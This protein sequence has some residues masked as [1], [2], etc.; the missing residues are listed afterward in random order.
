MS[1]KLTKDFYRQI[2]DIKEVKYHNLSTFSYVHGGIDFRD[3]RVRLTRGLTLD[4]N[5]NVILVGYSKFFCNNQLDNRDIEEDFKEQYAV[6][7][8]KEIYHCREKLDGSMI[9]LG[10]YQNELI[11]ST[12]SSVD[13]EYTREILPKFKSLSFV[14][15]LKQYLL[16]RNSCFIFEY[17]SPLNRVVVEYDKT[18]FVLLDE[19]SKDT[20]KRINI[21]NDFNFTRPHEYYLSKEEINNMV[22]NSQNFE[23][24]VIENNYNNYIKVKSNWW[25]DN[26]NITTD[27]FFSNKLT[28]NIIKAIIQNIDNLDELYS[29][30]NSNAYWKDKNYVGIIED[31]YNQLVLE[32]DKML[33]KYHTP[34]EISLNV[35]DGFIKALAITKLMNRDTERLFIKAITDRLENK[36]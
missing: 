29:Y 7:Q 1:M 20:F 35:K 4:E 5:N 23:G 33:E 14:N 11:C 28:K 19:I 15:E 27:I 17:I 31:E 36:S 9:I 26:K 34:K 8:D 24:Y 18:D 6:L 10:V 2:K 32:I 25:Y 16:D 12:T 21:D 22:E 3:E 13:N 30:Q